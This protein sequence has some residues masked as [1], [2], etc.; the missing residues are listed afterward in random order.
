MTKTA[1]PDGIKCFLTMAAEIFDYR[2]SEKK[3]L[4]V[5]NVGGASL[6]R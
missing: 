1:I 2:A 5:Q 6:L 4:N 3:F